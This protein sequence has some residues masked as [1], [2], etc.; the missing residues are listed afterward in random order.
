MQIRKAIAIAFVGLAAMGVTACASGP[1]Y[2]EYAASI[3]ALQS[4]QGRIWFYR[5]N[6]FGAAI[7]PDVKLNGEIVGKS[8]AGGFFYADRAAGQYTVST[9]T[10]AQRDLSLTLAAGEQKYVRFDPQMGIL[11]GTIKSVVVEPA[12]GQKAIQGTKFTGPVAK[13]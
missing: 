11:V 2:S 5:T 4:S 6:A 9:S 10:E 7:Q 8:T 1:S 3:P 12:E 13:K